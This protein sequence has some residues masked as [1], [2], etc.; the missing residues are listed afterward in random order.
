MP[1][2]FWEQG[3]S[4]SLGAFQISATAALRHFWKKKNKNV[5]NKV[6]LGVKHFISTFPHFPREFL[7]I[8]QDPPKQCYSAAG[9]YYT[10]LTCAPTA[11]QVYAP[12]SRGQH[13]QLLWRAHGLIWLHATWLWRWKKHGLLAFGKMNKKRKNKGNNSLE[14]KSPK[15][16]ENVNSK[17]CGGCENHKLS[18]T[19]IYSIYV[20][21]KQCSM[22]R[23]GNPVSAASH[24]GHASHSWGW[25]APGLAPHLPPPPFPRT[26]PMAIPQSHQP[27]PTAPGRSFASSL[28]PLL[29]QLENI[30]RH[31]ANGTRSGHWGGLYPLVCRNF[32]RAVEVMALLQI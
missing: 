26:L 9:P 14:I 31:G 29:L 32:G 23:A 25:P 12:L 1:G 8:S 24:R 4:N 3:T 11:P 7:W 6:E 2:T 27:F 28:Q 13:T 10:N 16:P 19:F 17:K 30:S 22:G 21:S 15:I 20:C 18:F 5:G